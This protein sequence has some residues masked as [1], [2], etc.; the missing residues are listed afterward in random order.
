MYTRGALVK[1]HPNGRINYDGELTTAYGADLKSDAA[2]K[3]AKAKNDAEK[4]LLIAEQAVKD[5]KLNAKDRLDHA[6]EMLDM[7]MEALIDAEAGS[8]N[9]DADDSGDENEDDDEE[10]LFDSA[11]AFNEDEGDQIDDDGKSAPSEDDCEGVNCYGDDFN[12][13]FGGRLV[14]KTVR[15]PNNFSKVNHDIL[16]DDSELCAEYPEMLNASAAFCEVNAG[17]MLYLPASWFH[18]VTSFGGKNQNGH[19]AFNYWFHPPDSL[20]SF[21]NPYSTDFWPNDFSQ[22]C[23]KN[24]IDS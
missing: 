22:R 11:K 17:E 4:E 6:E 2:A 13:E 24:E 10:G 8:E 3:A 16:D 1:V 9:E 20:D 12:L 21:Q 15:N 19:L 5:G 14:D 18:E 7:A 23:E